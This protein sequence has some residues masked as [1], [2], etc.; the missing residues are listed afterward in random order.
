MHFSHGQVQTSESIDGVFNLI[1]DA[2]EEIG[3]K[4]KSIDRTYYQIIGKSWI[5]KR[6]IIPEKFYIV[7]SETTIGTNIEIYDENYGVLQPSKA[8]I[9]PLLKSLAKKI[10]F[11]TSFTISRTARDKTKE[12]L[13]IIDNVP[14]VRS[15]KVKSIMNFD[16]L[17]YYVEPVGTYT[18]NNIYDINKLVFHLK[19]DHEIHLIKDGDPHPILKIPIKDIKDVKISATEKGLFKTQNDLILL[20]T[21]SVNEKSNSF[22]VNPVY[23]GITP[24]MVQTIN[25]D[26]N[27]KEINLLLEQ[28][29]AF[30]GVE[31]DDNAKL[32]L[33]ASLHGKDLCTGCHRRDS[34]FLFSNVSLCG[35]CFKERYGHL[36][37]RAET[38]E[39]YG[40][41]KLHLAG[42][43]FGD[44]ETGKMYLTK[45]H[46]IFNRIDKNR[47]KTWEI[48]IPLNLIDVDGWQINEESRRKNIIMGGLGS[49]NSMFAGG[50]ISESGKRHRIVISYTDEN[51][52]YQSPVFGIS[53]LSGIAIRDWT[54]HLYHAIIANKNIVNNDVSRN[55]KKIKKQIDHFTDPL[56]IAKLR[57]ARGET[58]KEEFEEMK[59][60]IE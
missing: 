14:E 30:Q 5:R 4:I 15:P 40:G 35:P 9:E 44:F 26:V 8:L 33:R 20:I 51:G 50:M 7:L 11:S 22:I 10:H 48:I 13:I 53:S 42:G 37:S 32:R 27:D 38:G 52:I 45:T 46:F 54:S 36:I 19:E 16:K 23:V 41:H 59:K 34:V 58:T 43:K 6:S 25:L 60:L 18:N 39:Y 1:Q 3:A 47:Q 2:I 12:G 57:F 56:T 17:E 29:K 55:E 24:E 31:D 21:F 49:N 28:I